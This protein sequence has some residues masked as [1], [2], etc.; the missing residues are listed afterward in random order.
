MI[1]P[2]GVQA[3]IPRLQEL[4]AS[5]ITPSRASVIGATQT[6]GKKLLNYMTPFDHGE[7]L[8]IMTAYYYHFLQNIL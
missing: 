4:P 1:Q 7:I 3:G 2:S 8:A 6:S 5:R